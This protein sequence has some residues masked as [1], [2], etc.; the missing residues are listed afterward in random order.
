MI[1]TAAVEE[2]VFQEIVKLG[3]HYVQDQGAPPKCKTKG[4]KHTPAGKV[5]PDEK[6]EQLQKSRVL[7]LSL[8]TDQ[9]Y[10]AAMDFIGGSV[11]GSLASYPKIGGQVLEAVRKFVPDGESKT[12][13]S[14][15]PWAPGSESTMGGDAKGEGP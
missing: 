3:K 9:A 13:G 5:C 14:T 12:S 4:E 8:P 2:E 7:R 15:S 1:A 6:E 11:A 10:V